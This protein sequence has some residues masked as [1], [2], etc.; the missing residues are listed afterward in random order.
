MMKRLSAVLIL[1]F[2][3]LAFCFSQ[4]QEGN[5]TYNSSKPGLFIDHPSLSFNTHV[6]IT[7][8]QNSQSVEAVVTGRIPISA[9][10]IADIH[11]DAGDALGM[12]KTGMT[13]VRIEELPSR[14]TAQS[15]PPAETPAQNT[16]PQQS[17]PP[18]APVQTVPAPVIVTPVTPAPAQQTQQPAPSPQ[19]LPVETIT[20]VEYIQV[21]T[22][23]YPSVSCA[24]SLLLA[25]LLLLILVII[26]LVVI[27]LLLLR[28][29]P[30][31]PWYYPF[32]LRRYFRYAKKRGRRILPQSWRS[33]KK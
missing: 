24:P 25:I 5:A 26:L 32:W 10:R 20:N 27:L 14:G 15:S 13:L 33:K 4:S 1:G 31:W 11:R 6:K 2:S 16:V 17:S 21:P 18:P 30:L 23:V 28:R 7:N 29:L 8:L 3:V 22:P 12:N 19:I 9:G